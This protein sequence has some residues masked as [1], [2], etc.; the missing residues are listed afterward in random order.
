MDNGQ[1]VQ[2]YTQPFTISKLGINTLQVKSVDKVGNEEIPQALNIE[3]TAFIATPSATSSTINNSSVQLTSI[4]TDSNSTNSTSNNSVSSTT[5]ESTPA[6]SPYTKS[7]LLYQ[8]TDKKVLG[9]SY[10]KNSIPTNIHEIGKEITP[11]KKLISYVP[12]DLEELFKIAFRTIL[13][14]SIWLTFTFIKQPPK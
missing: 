12:K 7:T 2:N 4:S 13:I 3:I 5:S 8:S 1:T 9:A 14:T 6:P 10:D 11:D